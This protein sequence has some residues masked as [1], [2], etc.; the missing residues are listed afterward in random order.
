MENYQLGL[1]ME[2]LDNE[3][4]SS[5]HRMYESLVSPHNRAVLKIKNIENVI[6]RTISY[7]SDLEE[8][9]KCSDLKNILDRLKK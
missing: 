7:F 5:Y 3:I 9:E 8:F 6:N 2:F 1:D 4:N